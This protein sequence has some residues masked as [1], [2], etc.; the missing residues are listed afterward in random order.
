MFFKTLAQLWTSKPAEVK[1]RYSIFEKKDADGIVYFCVEPNADRLK[2][3]QVFNLG[4][5]KNKFAN[6]QQAEA[7]I[8]TYNVR[9]ENLK[10][11]RF[12]KHVD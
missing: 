10:H 6:V 12:V 2:Y 5:G 11:R 1:P 4:F 3:R 9:R 8:W 7:A